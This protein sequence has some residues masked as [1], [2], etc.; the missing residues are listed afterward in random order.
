VAEG[1]RQIVFCLEYDHSTEPLDRHVEK[2]RRYDRLRK[3][4]SDPFVVFDA[5]P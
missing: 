3:I 4:M 2:L 1:Q 5:R